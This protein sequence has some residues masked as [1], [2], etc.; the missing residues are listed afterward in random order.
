MADVAFDLPAHATRERLS[1]LRLSIPVGALPIRASWH[2]ARVFNTLL[3]QTK[4][5][6]PTDHIVRAIGS[7]RQDTEPGSEHLALA[8]NATVAILCAQVEAALSFDP[9]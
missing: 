6:R 2:V 3:A 7:L 4:Q 9:E 1:A 8:D 5:V